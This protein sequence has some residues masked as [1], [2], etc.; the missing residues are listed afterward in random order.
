MAEH[1]LRRGSEEQDHEEGPLR[2]ELERERRWEHAEVGRVSHAV[3]LTDL[4]AVLMV[5]A[6]GF[7][8]FATWRTAEVT[9]LVF[10]I[11]DRPFMGVSKIEFEA[12]DSPDPHLTV[13][14]KN[15][16]RI[17]ATDGLV[18]VDARIDGKEAPDPFPGAMNVHETG[19]IPPDVDH[20]F[21]RYLTADSYRE[22]VSGK[23]SLRVDV[24]INYK[25][26][27]PNTQYCDFKWFVYDYRTATFRHAGG[28]NKCNG[29]QI[30]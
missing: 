3:G 7:S 1:R 16:G 24:H 8:A 20:F 2:E 5:I 30:Y 29:T 28:S 27:A 13:V 9:S 19:G 25:G 21:Y 23:A 6:T 10:A 12:T 17:P 18:S 4:L 11:A 22:V 15:F 14:Y 26:L